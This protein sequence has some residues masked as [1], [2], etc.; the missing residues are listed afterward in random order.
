MLVKYPLAYT[1]EPL[2]ARAVTASLA[3]G[4]H[5]VAVPV[6]ASSAAMRLRGSP[7]MLV[8]FP[9]AYTVDPPATNATTET[10]IWPLAFGSQA[11]AVPVVASSAAIALRDCP[12]M[13]VNIPP[14]YT[15]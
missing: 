10:N 5:E 8:K 3:F 11:V 6:A 9:P 7:P 15:V 2:T 4:F 1:V 13:L 14:A 12:P